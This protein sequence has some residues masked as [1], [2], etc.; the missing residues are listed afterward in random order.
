MNCP[1]PSAATLLSSS[2][3]LNLA[4]QGV[5]VETDTGKLR[6][7]VADGYAD[8]ADSLALLLSLWGHE[9][10]V[11][12]TGPEALRAARTH[13]PHVALLELVLEGID[14]YQVARLLRE[15]TGDAT[16]LVALTGFGDPSHRRKC[17]EIGF[18]YHLV[19]PVEPARLQKLLARLA[20]GGDVAP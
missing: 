15:Q 6:V 7:L 13:Q 18:K 9:P 3:E 14:G 2:G 19:K 1:T 5:R 17:K 20:P 11:A 16:L 8:A 12:R 10:I 4:A